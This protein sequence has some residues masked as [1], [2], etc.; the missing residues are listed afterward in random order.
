MTVLRPVLNITEPGKLLKWYRKLRK[1]EKRKEKGG[2]YKMMAGKP[3]VL[4]AEEEVFQNPRYMEFLQFYFKIGTSLGAFQEMG[5]IYFE[6]MKDS[7]F[8]ESKLDGYENDIVKK[9]KLFSPEWL[10]STVLGCVGPQSTDNEEYEK[11]A[12]VK[13]EEVKTAEQAAA[14]QANGDLIYADAEETKPLL[15]GLKD[16]AT[17]EKQ[18]EEVY[19][20]VVALTETTKTEEQEAT[21]EEERAPTPPDPLRTLAASLHA[22]FVDYRET[23]TDFKDMMDKIEP[24]AFE[25]DETKEDQ[26]N[27][28]S[29]IVVKT[30]KED[31]SM[32]QSLTTSKTTENVIE[33]G[34]ENI[35]PNK[36]SISSSYAIA[37]PKAEHKSL[38]TEINM[39]SKSAESVASKSSANSAAESVRARKPSVLTAQRSTD[40]IND[41]AGSKPSLA[42]SQSSVREKN[43]MSN[44]SIC[45]STT[46]EERINLNTPLTLRKVSQDVDYSSRR[47][48]EAVDFLSSNAGEVAQQRRRKISLQESID[49]RNIQLQI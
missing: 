30:A 25:S 15:D 29:I 37:T 36:E 39:I 21:K 42:S 19:E 1:Y 46:E 4:P 49:N 5:L 32:T 8:G 41:T 43:T 35:L 33:S 26:P 28:S 6:L 13:T 9:P 48:L 7:M 45:A 2:L 31:F 10:R 23:Y 44:S 24:P 12:E 27:E 47:V 40:L 34:S 14:L 20:D 18:Q 3:P 17:P 16:A 38:N 11:T 22:S